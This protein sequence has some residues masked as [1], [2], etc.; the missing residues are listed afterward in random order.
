M[1]SLDPRPRHAHQHDTLQTLHTRAESAHMGWAG[2]GLALLSALSR[3]R[4]KHR[5]ACA[6]SGPSPSASHRIHDEPPIQ[7]N[8][9][10]TPTPPPHMQM[11]PLPHATAQPLR[12]APRTVVPSR[13]IRS[14]RTVWSDLYPLLIARSAW[15]LVYHRIFRERDLA[16]PRVRGSLPEA[17]NPPHLLP[18]APCIARTR[19]AW[20]RLNTPRRPTSSDSLSQTHTRPPGPS[21]PPC[22]RT[23]HTVYTR[24]FVRASQCA[25]GRSSGPLLRDRH[26][27]QQPTAAQQ[28]SSNPRC[29]MACRMHTISR[30]RRVARACGSTPAARD[31]IPCIRTCCNLRSRLQ[32]QASI[33]RTGRS[34]RPCKQRKRAGP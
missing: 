29:S 8:P 7:T 15:P 11:H 24:S 12:L 31:R 18:S 27:M 33:R 34:Y 19:P 9:H 1:S 21:H 28:R 20:L 23:H 10:A 6:P 14:E 17:P 5:A 32:S 16:S 26:Q 2:T 13:P 3:S 25:R 22:P 4:E 30:C